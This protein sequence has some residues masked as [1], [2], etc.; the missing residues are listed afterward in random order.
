MLPRKNKNKNK[1]R[2]ILATRCQGG[3]QQR[4]RRAGGRA[5]APGV[6]P[7]CARVR[8]RRLR[9]AARPGAAA[10]PFPAGGDRRA[11]DV[12]VGPLGQFAR[13]ERKDYTG[14]FRGW[15]QPWP[16]WARGGRAGPG[17]LGRG[18]GLG[19]VRGPRV[20]PLCP[21][22][23]PQVAAAAGGL[24]GRRPP[25]RL[26]A[27]P[28]FNLQ[29]RKAA[30]TEA[31]AGIAMCLPGSVP[32]VPSPSP[33]AG[34]LPTD[35]ASSSRAPTPSPSLWASARCQRGRPE[36]GP[37]RPALPT[38]GRAGAGGQEGG[39][40]GGGLGCSRVTGSAGRASRSEFANE[41]AEA[42]TGK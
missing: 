22:P 33:E 31:A 6:A 12:A 36:R 24:G 21:A 2:N 38:A 42:Q 20:G 28:R 3:P 25:W 11:E 30:L 15:P 5:G 8:G 17:C 18:P 23:G 39:Q 41:E 7:P 16:R 9:L 26:F 37:G 4:T 13:G 14:G 29:N 40:E 1:K 19:E 10:P 32:Q 35:P 34:R 27:Q